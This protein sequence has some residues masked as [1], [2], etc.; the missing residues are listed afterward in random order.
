MIVSI[1]KVSLK[2]LA[3]APRSGGAIK[4]RGIDVETG[5]D[6]VEN[7]PL[8]KNN[9]NG[10]ADIKPQNLQKR[11]DLASRLRRVIKAWETGADGWSLGIA[12][13]TIRG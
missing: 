7:R 9:D 4:Y 13:Y 12:H 5:D 2:E 10:T 11:D 3:G 8:E 1:E 6:N